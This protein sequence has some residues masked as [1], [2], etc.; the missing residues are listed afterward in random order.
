[1]CDP[2]CPDDDNVVEN[3]NRAESIKE[4]HRD[5]EKQKMKLKRREAKEDSIFDH[6]IIDD[7]R[8]PDNPNSIM[9]N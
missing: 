2:N 4:Q 7:G 5:P 6:W 9:G 1:M 8:F 3:K